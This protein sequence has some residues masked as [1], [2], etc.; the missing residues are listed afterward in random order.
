MSQLNKITVL[1]GGV[2]G[3]QIAWHSA[4]KGKVGVL[5][6]EGYY[7]YPNPACATPDFLNVPNRSSV[8]EIVRLTKPV[9]DAG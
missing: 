8:P 7:H 6:G 5:T 3:G 2:L 4:F 9:H 1:G